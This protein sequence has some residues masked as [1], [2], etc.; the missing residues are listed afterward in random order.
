MQQNKT[1]IFNST[2]SNIIVTKLSFVWNKNIKC[3]SI[4]N[5][6]ADVKCFYL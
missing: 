4:N 1:C 6:T 2:Q 5:T 3:L